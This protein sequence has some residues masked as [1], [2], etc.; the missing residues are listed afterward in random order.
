MKAILLTASLGLLTM[1]FNAGAVKIDGEA[2]VAGVG[3]P[4]ITDPGIV[5]NFREAR[6][7]TGIKAPFERPRNGDWS[8]NSAAEVGAD[9][10]DKSRGT[11]FLVI[12]DEDAFDTPEDTAK[13]FGFNPP[14]KGQE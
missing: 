3:E 10:A 14:M 7:L 1:S 13:R 8:A 9:V 2:A 6:P 11:R 4:M 12:M 5:A